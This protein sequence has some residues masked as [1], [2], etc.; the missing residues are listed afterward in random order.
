MWLVA[1]ERFRVGKC[2]RLGFPRTTRHPIGFGHLWRTRALPF[3]MAWALGSTYPVQAA[4]RTFTLT[5]ERKHV[6]IGADLTYNAWTYNGTIPGPLLRAREGDQI[7]MHLINNT[8][9]A[10][11]IDVHAAQIA[12]EH[13]VGDPTRP[14]DYTFRAE[15]PGV[16]I[17]HGDAIPIVEQAS[18]LYGT[19]I[20]DPKGGWPNGDAQ[21]V[22]IV[23][24]E[25]YGLPDTHGFIV[26]DQRK[27]VEARS[28]F[29]VFNGALNKHGIEHPIPIK[30]RRPVRVFFLNAGPNLWSV[31]HIAGVIFTTVYKNGNPADAF[32]GLDSFSL[33]PS[34]GAVFEFRV[35]ETGDYR[36]M[37]LSRGH[38]H[39]GAIGVFRA[40]P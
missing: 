20:I 36:F 34:A 17:Y 16:F 3:F 21:E 22:V 32:H 15:V 33:A 25:F 4:T 7:T 39:Q 14:V 19:M 1:L 8:G 9:D 37:D 18:G 6:Q 11:G 27:M 31:F 35:D 10:H 28:D 38:Q 13:F 23:Q 26:G 24:S 30:V 2:L 40:T 29:I 12:P 5:V